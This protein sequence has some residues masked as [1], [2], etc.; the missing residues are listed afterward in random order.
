MKKFTLTK[1]YENVIVERKIEIITETVEVTINEYIGNNIR[2]M[3]KNLKLNQLELSIKLN[4]SR[5]SI[6]NIEA[7]RQTLSYGNLQIL[8]DV[9]KCTSVDILSF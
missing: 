1:T 7:G 2:M 9:F 4:I 3:R 6:A 5:G 8:C